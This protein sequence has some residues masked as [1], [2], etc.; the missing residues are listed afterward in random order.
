MVV[1]PIM[2]TCFGGYE[3]WLFGMNSLPIRTALPGGSYT[4]RNRASHDIRSETETDVFHI[5]CAK[6]SLDGNL[7]IFASHIH[8]FAEF[9]KE[10]KEIPEITFEKHVVDLKANK[11]KKR[12]VYEGAAGDFP[13]KLSNNMLLLNTMTLSKNGGSLLILFD[14][15]RE[16]V[17]KRIT[18][19]HVASDVLCLDRRRLIY[20]SLDEVVIYDFKS[21]R[22]CRTYPIP[23]RMANF[24]ATLLR[25][26]SRKAVSKKKH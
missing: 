11:I 17:S 6:R 7:V 14:T 18:I 16:K 19:P 24:H 4:T 22:V 23:R 10:P 8:N 3:K 25:Y 12:V 13:Q 2:R 26:P 20:A 9:I 5:A 1:F 21:E 15:A